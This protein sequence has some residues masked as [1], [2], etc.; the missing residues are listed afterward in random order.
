MRPR[1]DFVARCQLAVE[2]TPVPRAA[3]VDEHARVVGVIHRVREIAQLM[4]TAASHRHSK[5]DPASSIPRR[6]PWTPSGCGRRL[7]TVPRRGSVSNGQSPALR[8]EDDRQ[9]L[10]PRVAYAGIESLIE[11]DMFFIRLELSVQQASGRNW[12]A[13]TIPVP[14]MLP[15]PIQDPAGRHSNDRKW[16]KTGFCFSYQNHQGTSSRRRL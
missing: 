1:L 4:T 11:D 15:L 10:S 16:T 12:H 13:G 2:D 14:A 9:W 6:I 5:R 8:H 3:V 7:Q